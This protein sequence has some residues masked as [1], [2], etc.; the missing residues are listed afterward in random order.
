MNTKWESFGWNVIE[1]DGH[2]FEKI[3][4]SI[5][6]ARNTK[7]RPTIII[8]DTTKGKGVS[9]MQD[10]CAWHGN[11]PSDDEYEKAI[12]ELKN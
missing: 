8:A 5:D 2:D 11:V 10:T 4:M 9:F 12:K 6:R 3:L 7:G 1:T